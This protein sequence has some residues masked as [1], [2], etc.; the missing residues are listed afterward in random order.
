MKPIELVM[1]KFFAGLG[2]YVLYL[3]GTL[4]ILLAIVFLGNPDGGPIIGGYLG[5]LF[6][7]ALYTS[8]GLFFS[9]LFKDQITAWVMAVIG[10]MVL[11]LLGWLPIAAQLDSWIGG[12]GTFLQRSVGSLGH[13]ESMYKGLLSIN[14]LFYFVSFSAVFLVLNAL[15]VEQRMRRQADLT[16][17][18]AAVVMIAVAAMLNMVIFQL[19]LGRWDATEGKIYTISES[20]WDLLFVPGPSQVK[21]AYG[22]RL[23][24]YSAIII[25]I[26][27]VPI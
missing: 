5:L 15:T 11:H 19:P 21:T 26:P 13:F 9:G 8:V 20:Y 12:F 18:G 3:L 7:G 14:D 22:I 2:F 27:C 25:K 17:S 6:M 4:P 23:R 10:T 16:F 24:P 1:G